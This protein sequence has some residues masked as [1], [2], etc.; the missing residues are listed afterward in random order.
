MTQHELKAG[1]HVVPK[2]NMNTLGAPFRITLVDSVSVT[3]DPKTGEEFVS[4]P[5]VVGLINA[6]VRSRVRHTRKLNG[7]EIQFVRHALG[8]Q[9]KALA[10]FLDMTPEHY[11]R[12]E[13]GAKVMST[14]SEKLLRMAAYLA[15]YSKDPMD[16]LTR[17]LDESK[18]QPDVKE[19]PKKAKQMIDGFLQV[20]AGMKIQTV[21]S[22]GD[23]LHFEFVRRHVEIDCSAS[24]A[25]EKMAE[26]VA[27]SKVDAYLES[28]AFAARLREVAQA[29][30][31][32][33]IIVQ[34]KNASA[35]GRQPA[36][37]K[38]TPVEDV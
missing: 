25:A 1:V 8:V 7:T 23:E 35:G 38:P 3:V 30:I 33:H 17:R 26:R 18:I 31:A 6:V 24:D 10:E 19:T 15:T 34:I 32:D 20:F 37:Q 22:S 27:T 4:V 16:V 11:S 13:T 14:P 12:C 2:Y 21:F 9:A 36:A 28:P 29:S 5:D